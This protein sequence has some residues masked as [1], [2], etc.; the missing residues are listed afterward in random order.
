MSSPPAT[1]QQSVL[2]LAAAAYPRVY[3]P[4][5]VPTTPTYPYVVVSA[6]LAEARSYTLDSR[7]GMRGGLIVLQAFG[8]T[9]P[10]TAMETVIGA[11]LDRRLQIDGYAPTPSRLS[12]A[13]VVNGAQ[14]EDAGIVGLTATLRFTATKT[15]HS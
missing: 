11:L 10:D 9:L 2:A 15:A 12:L 5:Q 4:N 8:H 1:A 3:G 7:H 14:A 13:P 6:A